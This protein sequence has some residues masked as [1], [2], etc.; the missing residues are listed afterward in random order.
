M[1]DA[2]NPPEFPAGPL[3]TVAHPNPEQ[4]AGLIAR[5]EMLPGRLRSL[6][7]HVPESRQGLRYRHWTIRQII[8][9]LA[10]SHTNAIVRFKWALSEDSPTIKLYRQWEWSQLPDGD[11]PAL[12]TIDFLE[13]LHARWCRLL[14]KLARGD[15]QRTY[16]QPETGKVYSLGEALSVYAWHGDHHSAQIEWVLQNRP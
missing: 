16:R 1:S 13:S 3:A 12:E 15:F 6:L 14:R 7:I 8:N 10:D 11:D 2:T 9:H 4:I 5:I